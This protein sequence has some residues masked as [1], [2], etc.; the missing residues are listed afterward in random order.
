MCLWEGHAAWRTLQFHVVSAVNVSATVPRRPMCLEAFTPLL[1]RFTLNPG[2]LH[3]LTAVCVWAMLELRYV[4]INLSYILPWILWIPDIKTSMLIS[5]NHIFFASYCFQFWKW[6]LSLKEQELFA[7]LLNQINKP[8]K[9]QKEQQQV[10]GRN[11]FTWIN[12]LTPE[13][14]QVPWIHNQSRLRAGRLLGCSP[15]SDCCIARPSLQ[16]PIDL[17]AM[18]TFF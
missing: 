14:N 15:C 12:S 8:L 10:W 18:L 16:V 9:P 2:L 13:W 17:K 3:V 7:V 1:A 5:E 4:K 6:L 11:K